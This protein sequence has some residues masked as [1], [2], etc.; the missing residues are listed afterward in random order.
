MKVRNKRRVT[1]GFITLA[2]LTALLAAPVVQ[3]QE[4]VKVGFIYPDAG[5]FA[6][7]GL[8]MRDGFL[9]YW[10]QVGNKAGGRA[11]E[12]L[13]EN[14]GTAKADEGLTKARKL[15][16]RDKVHILGGVISTPVAY[17]LRTYVVEKNMPT[18]IM[19][20]GADGITQK[21]KSDYMFRSAFAN[22][23]S[24]HPLGEW[25]YKQGY[26]KAVIMAMDFGAGY[27]QIG[28]FARTF[29]EAGGQIIQEIYTPL[30]TADYAPYLASI[31][32][33][34]DVVA[35]FYAGAGAL[36]FVN[37]YAEFG[38]K[39]KI[40]LIGKGYL[41]DEVILPGLGDNA[42]GIVTSLHW[43]AAL[44][45]PANK[46]FLEAYAAKYKRPATTYAEQG[47]VGAQ[48]IA[49][50]LEAV[51]GNVENREAFLAALRKVEVD[52][53]R[54]KVKLDAYHNPIHPIYI[55]KVEK[56]GNELQ[57]T[58]I[59]TY[60]STSQFWKWG[61]DAYLAMPPYAEMKGKWAK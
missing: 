5:T 52:A 7:P 41:V 23:D 39:G 36:R 47:Y 4:P 42:V 19:N 30:A 16:E 57:N 11:V 48:M 49:Q 55:R 29:M 24:S 13:L 25:A 26:R 59:A 14:K 17:A 6:Q 22:S 44:A 34:A 43:S 3:A 21:Q 9:L 10:G 40:P 27:E 2:L 18:V 31:K 50:A 33:E 12:L 32:R 56:K 15:V 37:Q 28:G 20:A 8:D 46:R 58:V 60:P 38:L 53:P 45:A 1:V 61:P 35:V 54:G 51:K